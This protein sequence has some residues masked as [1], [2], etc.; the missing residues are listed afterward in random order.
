MTPS[1]LRRILAFK[2]RRGEC[3]HNRA[4]REFLEGWLRRLEENG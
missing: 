4:F 3:A 2:N 1:Q